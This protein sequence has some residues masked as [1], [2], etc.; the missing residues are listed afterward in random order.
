MKARSEMNFQVGDT[1]IHSSHGLAEVVGLEEKAVAGENILFYVVQ[2]RDLTIWIPSNGT[3]KGTLRR[4]TGKNEFKTL[5]AILGGTCDPLSS[6]RMERKG[7]LHKRMHEGNTESVCRL[8]RDLSFYRLT[9]KMN[10][11]DSAVLER[12]QNTLLDEWSYSQS[13]PLPQAKSD[14]K[15]IL[16]EKFQKVAA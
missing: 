7:Q 9:N 5:L 8:I 16:E 13:V 14:L 10:E 12:A 6:D 2:A 15:H 4:P 11:N 3:D 1:V